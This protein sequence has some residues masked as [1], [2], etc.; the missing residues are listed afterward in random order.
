MNKFY[1]F[2]L[3]V[4]CIL[5]L[6][7]QTVYYV[8][9]SGSGN[10]DGSSW[11]NAYDNL[12]TAID[13]AAAGD[14]IRVARGLYYG[15][16]TIKEGVNVYGS[17]QIGQNSR[18]DYKTMYENNGEFATILDGGNERRV[19]TQKN[20]FTQPT[21]WSGFGIQNGNATNDP[22]NPADIK[23]GGGAL[24]KQGMTLSYCI[25][26]DNT[27]GRDY[28]NTSRGGGIYNEGI[29]EYC[30]FFNNKAG[31]F[32]ENNQLLK[33]VASGGGIYN[34]TT[35]V[36]RNSVMSRNTANWGTGYQTG[37]GKGG[38]IY[39]L[40]KVENCEIAENDANNG[41]GEAPLGEE[42][43]GGGVYNMSGAKLIN[44]LIRNNIALYAGTLGS[45]G[46]VDNSGEIINCTIYD[47]HAVDLV[48]T[49]T[50]AY[51]GGVFHVS[52][53]AR[54]YNSIV[55]DNYSSNDVHN[56]VLIR[57]EAGGTPVLSHNIYSEA[58]PEDGE[59]NLNSDPLLDN[60]RLKAN[61]PAV[62]TGNNDLYSTVSAN[63]KDLDGNNRFVNGKI[64]RG[65]FEY[66][67]VIPEPN[68][69]N[70]RLYVKAGSQ[71]S[72]TSD[73]S[74][75]N[76][77][78]ASLQKALDFAAANPGAVTEIWVAAGEY[79]G[80][81]NIVEGVN[82]YGGFRGTETQ[83]PEKPDTLNNKTTLTVQ[84]P[85]RVLTQ[86]KHFNKKTVWSGFEITGG[87]ATNALYEPGYGG[88]AYIMKNTT[89]D[90]CS[91]HDNTAYSGLD[92]GTWMGGGVY[93][94]Q[95]VILHSHIYNNIA[96][97]GSLQDVDAKGGGVLMAEGKIAYSLINGNTAYK[98]VNNNEGTGYGGGI[99]ANNSVIHNC[100]IH[101]NTAYTTNSATYGKGYGGGIH[102]D[103]GCTVNSCTVTANSAITNATNGSV[104]GGGGICVHDESNTIYNSII[105]NN[106]DTQN[107]SEDLYDYFGNRAFNIKHSIWKG[108]TGDD[109]NFNRDMDPKLTSSYRLSGE[110]PAIDSGS[111][112]LYNSVSD[113]NASA[114]Y[115]LDGNDRVRGSKLDIG[116][117]EHEE[118]AGPVIIP[119]ADKK[120]YV[121]A[122][123]GGT[124]SNGSSWGNAL[125]SLHDA[126]KYANNYSNAVEEIIIGIGE[127][128]IKDSA[129]VITSDIRITGGYRGQ[130]TDT[131]RDENTPG[132]TVL[133]PAG[134]WRVIII[135]G[136]GNNDIV[137]PRISNLA[138]TGGKA[139]SSTILTNGILIT[140]GYGGGVYSV[141]A[142]QVFTNV[143]FTGNSA[144][145]GGGMY[146]RSGKA[147]LVNTTFSANTAEKEGGA[148]Y[149]ESENTRIINT[150]LWGNTSPG[151]GKNIF[152]D[153]NVVPGYINTLVEGIDLS[154]VSKGNLNGKNG[155][156][157]PMFTATGLHP[158]SLKASSPLINKGIKDTLFTATSVDITGHLR[159]RDSVDLGAYEFQEASPLRIVFPDP[160]K[161]EAVKKFVV[162]TAIYG[163][164][165]DTTYHVAY[166]TD[167]S[168]KFDLMKPADSVLYSVIGG[169]D[170][171]APVKGV[172][173]FKRVTSDMSLKLD[174]S[175][176]YVTIP[177]VKGLLTTPIAGKYQVSLGDSLELKLQLAD[178][179]K[180]FD[181]YLI[182]NGDTVTNFVQKD[183][184]SASG[185]A[186]FEFNTG[187]PST[188]ALRLRSN[189]VYSY[190][191]KNITKSINVMFKGVIDNMPVANEKEPA[192]NGVKVYA[193]D[194]RLYIETD[195]PCQLSVYT[196]TGQLHTQQ[197]IP[198]GTTSLQ[199]GKGIYIIKAGETIRKVLIK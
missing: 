88:G 197:Q 5:P 68:P 163:M 33:P 27:A 17:Y 180:E 123:A 49:N 96:Y 66:Y 4:C 134:N 118:I 20:N 106:S 114:D 158:F 193:A 129:L 32:S 152:N 165:S 37:I 120:L 77:A 45:G 190:W 39:N 164:S 169:K 7:A 186:S 3:T 74:G 191:I 145:N 14:E 156:N 86:N 168:F 91:I 87:D 35:G 181:L 93:S 31:D 73:G 110:S 34:E 40:G 1:A 76:K 6:Q 133:K 175:F 13:G 15:G 159:V 12:Q 81:F 122:S 148:I 48:N 57:A 132:K 38:G 116:A 92:L 23:Q 150:I 36:I 199:P 59:A 174:T 21:T 55:W 131:I 82:V 105:W 178:G 80:P 115:D 124:V 144:V 141:Y 63:D 179:Y 103:E 149:N 187:D 195:K 142:D 113:I 182:L 79:T 42:G 54:L 108:A 166:N 171:V 95:G 90:Y 137:K 101:N 43:S 18:P 47:N 64:D 112:E 46:G 140:R 117:F 61:S 9:E 22:T 119:S 83:R 98:G 30:I 147:S 51:G 139:S 84:N 75:W 78:L 25:L 100:L 157:N 126:V 26:R 19:L 153:K 128:E 60:Y 172:Y 99:A 173:T 143:V 177:K 154:A 162:D 121:R 198:A 16:F 52:G 8:S 67:E 50:N 107:G 2:L 151:E 167:F 89:L 136:K 65:A 138:V 192:D 41:D 94:Y 24:I 189:E 72:T 10:K 58:K 104:A 127:Y 70:K 135:A 69:T 111:A 125:T 102:V 161:V 176:I 71:G 184:K 130:G 11:E 160:N 62:D 194:N 56:D 97:K 109:E 155:W 53:T 188:Y 29:I 183:S 28:A 170:T 44:C 146:I 196:F 85:N 185:A